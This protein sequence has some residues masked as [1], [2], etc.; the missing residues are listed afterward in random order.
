MIAKPQI[1]GTHAKTGLVLQVKTADIMIAKPKLA[2]IHTKTG[3]VLQVK[4]VSRVCQKARA[5]VQA[6]VSFSGVNTLPNNT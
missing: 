4:I 6:L 3:L 5:E 2:G 1:A